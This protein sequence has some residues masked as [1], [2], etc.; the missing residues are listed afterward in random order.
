MKNFI[1]SFLLCFAF[2][3][4]LGQVNLVPNPSCE[5]YSVCPNDNDGSLI[6]QALNWSKPNI[7]S[8]DY[9][10][11]CDQT[12]SQNY[13]VPNNFY[14]QQLARMGNAY[15]GIITVGEGTPVR[16]YIQTQLSTSLVAGKVYCVSFYISA[17]DK[18]QYISN[19]IG[20][21]FSNNMIFENTTHYLPLTPHIYNNPNINPLT[22]KINW[23]EVSGVFVAQGG[24]Q[25]MVIGNFLPFEET[26]TTHFDNWTL[27][28]S[29]HYIDDVSVKL[30]DDVGM[31]EIN[32]KDDILVFPNPQPIII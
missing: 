15:A 21:Y 3:E 14:G 1:S 29:Y 32:L 4:V 31:D 19:D 20:A 11:S 24:E 10:N 13:S 25:Y 12:S 7:Y 9:F 23:T 22:N 5:E 17:S 28:Y 27:N 18:S 2:L 8:P 30:C 6:E 16:E 26:D